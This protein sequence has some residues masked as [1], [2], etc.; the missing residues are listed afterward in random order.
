[1]CTNIG[2]EHLRIDIETAGGTDENHAWN[3]IAMS[4]VEDCWIRKC[5]ALHFGHAGFITQTATRITI[6]SCSAFEP[7]SIITGERRYNFDMSDA[8]QLVLVSNA[9]ATEGRHDYVSNGASWTSG[10]VFLDCRSERAHASSEGHR[11]WTTGF[12]YDNVVFT[13]ANVS[14]V[15]GLYNRGNYGT[16]HGW[17]IAHSVAWRCDVGTR[18][19]I[20]QKPPTGQN[21]AIGCTGVVTGAKPPAPFAEPE[22]FIE[23]TNRAGLVPRSLYRAQLEERLGHPT[24]T[25]RNEASPLPQ[26]F[27]LLDPFPNP[28]NGSTSIAYALADPETIRLSIVDILGREV[29]LLTEGRMGA[30]MHRV[31][32]EPRAQASGIYLCRLETGRSTYSTKVMLLR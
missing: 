31:Q 21:Y 9:L 11:R 30:G 17:A 20:V 2:I 18:T 15:L 13:S 4:L 8:S 7:I 3:A 27:R 10:C 26:E 32:W 14:L 16:S 29:A 28:F 23:G 25:G 1:L 5:T 22:G 6:D 24:G 12:L 19:I